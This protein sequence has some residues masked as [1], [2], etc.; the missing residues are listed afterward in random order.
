LP[1][2][3]LRLKLRLSVDEYL[4]EK[5]LLNALTFIYFSYKPRYWYFEII[6]LLRRL[7]FASFIS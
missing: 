3:E 4:S 5:R 1:S 7:Y 6:E 2:E